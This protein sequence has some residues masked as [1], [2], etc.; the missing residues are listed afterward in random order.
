M[1]LLT[2]VAVVL[3]WLVLIANADVPP[4][5]L[6]TLG[7]CTVDNL[8]SYIEEAG[9]NGDFA[10]V[11]GPCTD[12]RA[13]EARNAVPT[14]P[15]PFSDV[16]IRLQGEY[17]IAFIARAVAGNTAPLF[18]FYDA[19]GNVLGGVTYGNGE[20]T[21]DLNRD[22]YPFTS[23]NTQDWQRYQ[24]C[25]DGRNLTLYQDCLAVAAQVITPTNGFNDDQIIYLLTNP[26]GGLFDGSV[27]SLYFINCGGSDSATQAAVAGIQCQHIDT[28]CVRTSVSIDTAVTA[29]LR[30]IN[31]GVS[32]PPDPPPVFS[33]KG[34][35]GQKGGAGDS[36]FGPP[37]IQGPPGPDGRQ[38]PRG[39]QG[40]PGLP[41]RKGPRGNP[42]L[43]GYPG[44]Q[45]PP[46]PPGQPFVSESQSDATDSQAG[47]YDKGPATTCTP[48]HTP[49]I[50]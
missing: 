42:G 36:T 37:G 16:T 21:Y 29:F 30:Q 23:L 47:D 17:C 27:A 15:V 13:Y 9:I 1:R 46:G 22:I 38:G 24:L 11:T 2:A 10:D 40:I 43:P 48:V 35:K 12:V 28:D 3:T 41:G 25:S 5:S 19:L 18:S 39:P 8:F 45:G 32:P 31:A 20:I 4:P 26:G 50:L 14:V 49:N 6:Q 33:L 44:V 7:S 34:Q